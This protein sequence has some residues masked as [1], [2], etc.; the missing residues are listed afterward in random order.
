MADKALT[1]HLHRV[2]GNCIIYREDKDGFKFLALKRHPNAKVYPGLWC[3]PGGGMDRTD[4]E[5]LPKTSPDGWESPV[6]IAT[7]REILEESGLT[8]GELEYLS[9]F[10]FIRPDDIPVVGFRFAAPYLSG[11]VVL[12]PTD[13]TEHVWITAEKAASYDFLGTIAQDIQ[14]LHVRLMERAKKTAT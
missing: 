5:H 13:A 7:R 2:V 8:V 4:Y 1:S 12:D 10:T 14:A 11:E 3:V 6:E 9:H